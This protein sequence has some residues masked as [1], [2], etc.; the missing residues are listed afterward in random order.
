VQAFVVRQAHV[1][2][3]EML[4]EMC[5]FLWPDAPLEEHHL[6][7]ESSLRS[8]LSGTLP[9][10]VLVAQDGDGLLRGFLQVVLR[11]HADGCDVSQPVGS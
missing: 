11:S 1:A 2:D 8:G 6:E 4:A 5:V 7:M 9:T 10:A 3:V